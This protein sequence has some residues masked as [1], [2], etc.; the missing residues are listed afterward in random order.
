MT[1]PPGKAT[2]RRYGLTEAEWIAL[3]PADG[4]CPVCLRPPRNGRWVTDHEH[5]YRWK[6]KQPGER[7]RHVRGLLCTWCNFRL[8]RKG[9]TLERARRIV[10]YLERHALNVSR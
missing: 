8:L 5:V 2:L 9:L 10:A 3:V 4:N 1:K 6:H 7:K